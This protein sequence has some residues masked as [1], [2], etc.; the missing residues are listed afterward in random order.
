MSQRRSR[1]SIARR[2]RV[3]VGCEGECEVA[4]AVFLSKLAD[5]AGLGLHF[6]PALVK[7]GGNPLLMLESAVEGAKKFESDGPFLAK[8]MLLDT[9][10]RPHVDPEVLEKAER[11]ARV[12]GLSVIWQDTCHEAFVLRHFPGHV[13]ARPPSTALAKTGLSRVWPEWEKERTVAANLRRKLGLDD[14]RRAAAGDAQLKAF[15]VQ[16]GLL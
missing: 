10:C 5:E 3:F 6:V 2:K 9:D 12:Q 13:N 4:Y 14:V 11:H 15:L 8:T 16:I 1:V 7:R